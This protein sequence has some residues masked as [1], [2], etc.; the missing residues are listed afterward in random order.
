[1]LAPGLFSFYAEGGHAAVH[2]QVQAVVETVETRAGDSDGAGPRA[3]AVWQLRLPGATVLWSAHAKVL[4]EGAG[5]LRTSPP[6]SIRESD[7]LQ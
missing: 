4:A 5:L 7:G 6:L 1:M 3:L 2:L